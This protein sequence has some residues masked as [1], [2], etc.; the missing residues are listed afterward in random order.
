MA[1]NDGGN[2]EMCMTLIREMSDAV[3]NARKAFMNGDACV[4]SRSYLH[5]KLDMLMDLLPEA[6]PQAEAI[7]REEAQIRSRTDQECNVQ[8][9]KAQ[10]QAQQ[11]LHDAQQQAMAI[12]NDAQIAMTN[13]ERQVQDA[14]RRAQEEGSRII[15]QYN[16]EAAAIRAKAEADRDEL[17]SKENVYRM[18]M[19][20]ADEM[21]ESTRKELGQLRQNTFDYLDHV[22][23]EVDR[24]LS[25]LVSD[26]RLERG[27]L[28]NH[29]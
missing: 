26:I 9:N 12:Q 28:N 2:V 4:I 17:I 19:V 11:I 27:E 22:M 21:R 8:L 7:L 20:E 6:L 29:R 18:A 1:M 23:G 14:Q 16:Q 15:Q 25:G 3:E 24:C 5:E 10:A 13:A